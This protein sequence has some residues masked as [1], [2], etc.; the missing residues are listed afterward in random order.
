[1]RNFDKDTGAIAYV[2][3]GVRVAPASPTMCEVYEDFYALT[4][5]VVGAMPVKV[6][7]EAH[8]TGIVLILGIVKPLTRRWK[9]LTGVFHI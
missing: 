7:H 9:G 1:M 3:A 2:Q 5:D 8:A 4:D 6:N